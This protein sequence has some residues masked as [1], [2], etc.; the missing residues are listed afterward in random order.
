MKTEDKEVLGGEEREASGDWWDSRRL[1]LSNQI[2]WDQFALESQRFQDRACFLS[3]PPYPGTSYPIV[4]R[5]DTLFNLEPTAP[6]T[7]PVILSP[8]KQ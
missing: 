2:S 4:N 7:A 3:E 8:W 6:S 1:R 5:S